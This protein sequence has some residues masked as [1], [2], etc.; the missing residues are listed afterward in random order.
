MASP[1]LT[2]PPVTMDASMP[3]RP[4]SSLWSPCRISAMRE[5]GGASFDISMTTSSPW[6]SCCPTFRDATS[7][8]VVVHLF[9]YDT[10]LKIEFLKGLVVHYQDLVALALRAFGGVAVAFDPQARRR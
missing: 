1:T 9:L 6:A 10:R 5:H 7:M 4:S 3:R 8:P 2:V